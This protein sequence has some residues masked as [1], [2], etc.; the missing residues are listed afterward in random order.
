MSIV[1]WIVIAAVVLFAWAGWRRGFVAGV[2]SFAGFLGGGLL[3]AFVLP[4]VIDS[5]MEPGI[6]AAVVL[7]GAVLLCA[8]LGQALASI[9]GRT[10]RHGLSWTPMRIVDSALGLGLN[11]VV[12]ALVTWIVITA[13]AVL[14]NIGPLQT[15]R[16]SKVILALDG[17]IPNQARDAFI[18]MRDAISGT[19]MPR[20]FAG[21]SEVVG[22]DVA[23]PDPE[24][25]EHP[26]MSQVRAAV[27]RVFGS[28]EEC[29]ETVSGSGF[30]AGDQYVLTNAHVVAGLSSPQVQV[31]PD[32]PI[33]DATVVAFDPRM[34]VAVLHVDGLD[35]KP[36]PLELQ[37]PAS[38]DDA[39][40]AGFPGGTDFDATSARIRATIQARGEDIYGH[41]G[42]EREVYS[43]RGKVEPGNSGGPLL[44]LD[45]RVLGMVFGAGVRDESTGFAISSPELRPILD[46]AEAQPEAVSTGSCRIRD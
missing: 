12:F 2:L 19:A 13:I 31:N 29:E 37:A 8:L 20:V 30:V 16:D 15:V 38:G 45:G 40:V 11:V 36:L 6:M 17:L 39:V 1:D 34:D 14:P 44:T 18:E 21:L 22:P 25:T 28:A 23:A 24:A 41:A 3:A 42:V 9:L 32:E 4:D 10:L 26:S 5:H 46:A 33:Y 35:V 43:F 7:V 27:V